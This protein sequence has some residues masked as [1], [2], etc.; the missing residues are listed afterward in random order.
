MYICICWHWIL[1]WEKVLRLAEQQVTP[2]GQLSS[3]WL[4]MY[5][6]TYLLASFHRRGVNSF[7]ALSALVLHWQ[8]RIAATRLVW[9]A[10]I[11]KCSETSGHFQTVGHFK[12]TLKVKDQKGTPSNLPYLYGPGKSYFIM[13]SRCATLWTDLL[14]AVMS[15]ASAEIEIHKWWV[16]KNSNLNR[17][18]DIQQNCLF[19]RS[20]LQNHYPLQV[21]I[22]KLDSVWAMP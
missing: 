9:T 15:S 13:W 18:V 19:Q 5:L 11:L 7:R 4:A 22:P 16:S 6:R 10:V 3:S 14:L 8:T 17:V 1:P 20:K 21:K 12:C 2:E